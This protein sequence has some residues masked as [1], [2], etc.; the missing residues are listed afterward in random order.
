MP[1][2]AYRSAAGYRGPDEFI[3]SFMGGDIRRPLA[4]SSIHVYLDV[5]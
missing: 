3:V 1:V 4:P 2:I 5:K